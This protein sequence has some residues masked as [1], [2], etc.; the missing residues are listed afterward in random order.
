MGSLLQNISTNIW[1]GFLALVVLTLI[2]HICLVWLKNL[3]KKWWKRTDYIWLLLT[4]FGLIGVTNKVQERTSETQIELVNI[5]I[6]YRYHELYSILT[7]KDPDWICRKF[8]R[9]EYSPA[10]FDAVVDDFNKACQWKSDMF[11]I[12]AKIDS[13]N[14][15]LI[16]TTKIPY[17]NDNSNTIEFKRW[18]LQDIRNYNEEV[19]IKKQNEQINESSKYDTFTLFGP[20]LLI[21]GLSL[22]ITKV[23]G[24][25]K[26]EKDS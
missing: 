18:V 9:S 24:E 4:A 21:L 3:S 8:I 23:S 10:N 22:R 6:P 11:N 16:D 13:P 12:V 26:H 25:L 15:D 19:A 5:R 14:Y 7:P 17:L 1:C 2:L 20:I